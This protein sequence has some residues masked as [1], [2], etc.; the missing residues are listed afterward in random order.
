MPRAT[1]D[2]GT[3]QGDSSHNSFTLQRGGKTWWFGL[4][5]VI[6]GFCDGLRFPQMKQEKLHLRSPAADVLFPSMFQCL[7]VSSPWL[8]VATRK[9]LLL[10]LASPAKRPW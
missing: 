9:L 6:L 2:M 1:M 8:V 5:T 4:V 3:A 10:D 7:P